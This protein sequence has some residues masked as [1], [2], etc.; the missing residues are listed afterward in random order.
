[1]F[2]DDAADRRR[3]SPCQDPGLCQVTAEERDYYR[4]Q[5][6][7]ALEQMAASPHTFQMD[8]RMVNIFTGWRQ[9]KKLKEAEE[10]EVRAKKREEILAR[11][12][13]KVRDALDPDE[14][15]VL[16]SERDLAVPDLVRPNPLL[17]DETEAH[18]PGF[19]RGSPM[20]DYFPEDEVVTTDDEIDADPGT[21]DSATRAFE[22]A[23]RV[24]IGRGERLAEERRLNELQRARDKAQREN[25]RDLGLKKIMAALSEDERTALDI[26]DLNDLRGTFASFRDGV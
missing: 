22:G 2:G 11:A 9:E 1:M 23:S 18:V 21:V 4:D 15:M 3:F 6:M 12:L 10:M 19:H 16:T 25:L 7:D 20:E 26:I 17:E 13:R 14:V 8:G 5:L 24:P